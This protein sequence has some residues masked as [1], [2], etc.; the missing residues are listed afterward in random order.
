MRVVLLGPP[1]VGKGTQGRRLASEHGWALI[2]TGEMLREAVARRTPLGIE[3]QKQMDQGLLVGDE[4]MIGLVNER[5]ADTDAAG[6]F[7]LDGFPRTVPQA[8]ALD[9]TLTRRGHALD[10]AVS[11]RAPDVELVR[12]M[13]ARRECPVCKRAY[14]L[15]SWPP[16]DGRHCDDHPDVDLIQR[17]DDT[18]E[19]VKRRL[20][21][22]G[23]QTAPLLDYYRSRG[24]LREVEGLGAMDDVYR[25]LT[26]TLGL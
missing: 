25:A 1:G 11:L 3:A 7:V 17:A 10:A 20:V 13:S 16:R 4:V 26:R 2:S 6:G 18:P 9:V 14:N 12:R 8:D 21:V 22:Y 19:T 23:Q 24:R 5:S 15:V